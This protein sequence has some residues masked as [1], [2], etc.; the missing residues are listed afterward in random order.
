MDQTAIEDLN[1]TLAELTAPLWFTATA[2]E[3]PPDQ[4]ETPAEG[5]EILFQAVTWRGN[6]R[7]EHAAAYPVSDVDNFG[8]EVVASRFVDAARQALARGTRSAV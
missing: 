1:R 8:C 4:E 3:V 6:E 5:A 2:R 7:L